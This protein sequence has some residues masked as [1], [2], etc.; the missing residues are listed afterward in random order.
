MLAIL[1]CIVSLIVYIYHSKIKECDEKFGMLEDGIKAESRYR[2]RL[3][4]EVVR[5]SE[6]INSIEKVCHE[7]HKK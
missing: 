5:L 7:K 2:Y 4:I 6:K 1:G 3:A